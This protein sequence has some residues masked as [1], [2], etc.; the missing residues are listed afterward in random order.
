[1]SISVGIVGLGRVGRSILRTN[2]IQKQGGRFN[3]KV[4]CDV[5]PISQIAYLLA[6]DSTYGV[7]P[8]TLDFEGD[9]L[10]IGGKKV[11]YLQV[12]RRHS[13]RQDGGL[14]E[15]IDL[16]IDVLINATGTAQIDDLRNLIDKKIAKK[17]LCSWNIAG[18]DMS[19]V[20]GVNEQ[21]YDNDKHHII[22]A[23]TCTGN[24][25]TPI[26]YILNKYIGIEYA[27]VITIHPVLS[28]QHILDGFHKNAHLGRSIN[29]SIIPT[30]TNVGAST[31][32]VLPELKGKLD[33]FS[34]RV[35]TEIV[36]VMDITATLSR[37][38]SLEECTELLE[39]SAKYEL[40]G[41]LHCD[42]GAWGHDKVSIDYIGSEFSCII[43]MNHLTLSCGRQL[44]I[45]VMHD[46]ERGYCCRALDILG[47]LGKK[48]KPVST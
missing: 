31:E 5:M 33:S 26:A 7:P 28:D 3:I 15:L 36:S 39:K 1:M 2:Y 27:R 11:R 37:E 45:S 6:H 22:S 24:A 23:S 13:S 41:I 19:L 48:F 25:M 29:A 40:S 9:F 34:Y 10:Y 35:P 30:S 38:T 4:L 32:L 8:F 21:Q 18:H 16:D 43:L 12:D 46:N 47:V 17:I 44:G 14:G 20:Y 42:Y